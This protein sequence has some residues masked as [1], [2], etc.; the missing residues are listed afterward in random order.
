MQNKRG[1][2]ILAQWNTQ[3]LLITAIMSIVFSVVLAGLSYLFIMFIIPLGLLARSALQ[4]IWYIPA[5]FVAYTLRRPGSVLVS[6]SMIRVIS[7]VI[8]PYGWLELVGLFVVALPAELVFYTTGYK[9]FELPVL[10]LV[11]IVVALIRTIATWVPLG[12][13]L[14]AIPSQ[15]AVVLLAVL[16]G[17][18]AALLAKT[19]AD[20]IAKTGVLSRYEIGK[21]YQEEI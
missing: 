9:N 20:S 8:S 16:S 12:I 14:L 18:I 19:L 4:G 1:K 13:N 5:I 6:E 15:V 11:G 3:D 2:S 10:M 17:A 21:E 7:I